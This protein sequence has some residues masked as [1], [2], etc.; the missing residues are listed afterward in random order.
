MKGEREIKKEW[1]VTRQV[2]AVLIGVYAVNKNQKQAR[3]DDSASQG[4]LSQG[5]LA[6]VAAQADQII[7]FLPKLADS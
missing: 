7:I 3:N 6:V 4:M 5:L 1:L 2:S